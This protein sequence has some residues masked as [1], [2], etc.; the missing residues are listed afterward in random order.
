MT[1]D[2]LLNVIYFYEKVD[3][4]LFVINEGKTKELKEIRA[5]FYLP[6]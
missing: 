4:A 6:E 1:W 3:C 5:K 2:D